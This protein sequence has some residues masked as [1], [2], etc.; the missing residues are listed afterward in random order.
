[1]NV[2]IVGAGVIGTVYGAQL[3]TAGHGISVLAHG[4]RT[5]AIAGALMCQ[6]SH[7][8]LRLRL[9]VAVSD[10]RR[11]RHRLVVGVHRGTDLFERVLRDR[12]GGEAA[13]TD[14]CSEITAVPHQL[15]AADSDRT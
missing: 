14:D 15:G 11:R 12:P 9:P 3:G 8:Q 1:M 4:D 6:L 2:L 7:A 10:D 5:E 13:V